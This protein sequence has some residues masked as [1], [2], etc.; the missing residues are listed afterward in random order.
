[1]GQ[2]QLLPIPARIAKSTNYLLFHWSTTMSCFSENDL[3]L[4]KFSQ[5]ILR[6]FF[7]A[8]ETVIFEFLVENYAETVKRVIFWQ[9]RDLKSHM[10]SSLLP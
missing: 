6:T 3:S 7:Q 1:M 4:S 2:N 9:K 8:L 5:K 10:L